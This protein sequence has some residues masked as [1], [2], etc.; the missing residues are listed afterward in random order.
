MSTRRPSVGWLIAGAYCLTLLAATVW[1][2]YVFGV[3]VPFAETMYFTRL[4]ENAQQYGYMDLRTSMLAIREQQVFF[5]TMMAHLTGIVFGLPALSVGSVRVF[6]MLTPVFAFA[7]LFCI[8]QLARATMRHRPESSRVWFAI[9]A[10]TAIFS[11][12][13]WETWSAMTY[14]FTMAVAL[15][16]SALTL[17]SLRKHTATVVASAAALCFIASFTL[18]S[19]LA[20]W[21]AA[22]P[23]LCWADGRGTPRFRRVAVIAWM[24]SAAVTFGMFLLSYVTYVPVHA[25]QEGG[26][27]PLK[28]VL[29]FFTLLG[30]PVAGWAQYWTWPSFAAGIAV[31]AATLALLR[32][33]RRSPRRQ[34]LLPWVSIVLLCIVTAAMITFG[35]TQHGSVTA[36]SSRFTTL[37]CPLLVSLGA[38]AVIEELQGKRARWWLI[39]FFVVQGCFLVAGAQSLLSRRIHLAIADG[40]LR[41]HR[42]SSDHCL[43]RLTFNI[44]EEA[45]MRAE[46]MER[47]GVLE[48]FVLPADTP[49][50][51]RVKDRDAAWVDSVEPGPDTPVLVTGWAIRDGC[52][53]WDVVFT[54][55]PE[56]TL[57][58]YTHAV[59]P[60]WD[61]FKGC[62]TFS[63]WYLELDPAKLPPQALKYP[64]DTWVYDRASASLI[65]TG[66][67][68]FTIQ[69]ME[70]LYSG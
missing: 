32:R 33:V 4:L 57:V 25:P 13:H 47:L 63:G 61:A 24:L 26:I 56:R 39:C 66:A 11:L 36:L 30:S 5:P 52:A 43:G 21:V 1:V 59:R 68:R 23:L 42:I 37:L 62:G 44:P 65:P 70:I 9:F 20:T 18:S 6:T 49:V 60:R 28:Y 19:G 27:L 15:S 3:P 16:L 12:S 54:A 50:G 69:P 17:L 41:T 29:Y 2:A 7:S 58:A 48:E 45:R 8:L 53:A 67:P 34:E 64:I 51:K 35:R 31:S 40:C 38:I 55:G 14:A 10:A 22:L 46:A